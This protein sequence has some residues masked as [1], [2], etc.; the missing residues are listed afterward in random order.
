VTPVYLCDL[1]TCAISPYPDLTRL[2]L[3]FASSAQR[4]KQRSTVLLLF[5]VPSQPTRLPADV[6][7]SA[8]AA[9]TA[10]S[11]TVPE[12][13]AYWARI[14]REFEMSPR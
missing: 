3:R 4:P 6:Y 5:S 11:R 2:G 10:A 8:A 14:G 9:A 1:V 13:I 12:Q 7:D